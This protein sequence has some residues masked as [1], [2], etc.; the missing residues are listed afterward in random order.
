[1]GQTFDRLEQT[2]ILTTTLALKLKK[3]VGFRNIALQNYDD[4]NWNSVHN[5]VKN[6][7][8]DLAGF[9]KLVAMKL[10]DSL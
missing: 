2:G 9:A 10:D 4:I 1:M 8:A 6:Y 7:M 5:I 3:A